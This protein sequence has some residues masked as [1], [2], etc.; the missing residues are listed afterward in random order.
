MLESEFSIALIK[1]GGIS[2]NTY[3]AYVCV[4]VCVTIQVSSIL[5]RERY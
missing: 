1:S 3:G 2:F 4:Y 5:Y